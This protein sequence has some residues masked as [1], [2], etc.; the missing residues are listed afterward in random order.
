MIPTYLLCRSTEVGEEEM[1]AAAAPIP[2]LTVITFLF[3]FLLPTIT[4][5]H[6]PTISVKDF[7]AIGDGKHYDTSAIQS[8]IDSCACHT[9]PCYVTFPTGTYLTATFYLKSNVILD[10][11]K[12][13]TILGGTK[14]EDY[15]K[16]SHKWYVILA[17]NASNVGITGG[18]V[19]D[20]QGSEFVVKLDQRKNVMVSWNQT[21]ACSGDEC[22]PRLV[23]FLDSTNVSVSNVTFTQPAYWCLH[24]VRCQNTSIH[25]VSIYG[26]F[27]TPNND[28]IDIEDSNNTVITRCHIDTGDDAICPKT[29]TGPLYN[30]TATNS[31]IRT[32]SSAIKLGSASWFEFKNLVFDNITIVDSH[33]GL[34]FQIRDGGDVNDVTFSN[35]NIS[36]RYYHPSWWGRAEPI[37]VT[38]CPRNS[39]SKEGSEG[40]LLRNL[41]F[42]NINLTYRRW[43]NYKGGLVDYRPGC[44]GLVNHSIAGIIMEHIDGLEVENVNMKWMDGRTV[45]WNNPLDFRPSTVNNISLLNFRSGFDRSGFDTQ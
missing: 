4:R 25:D 30:L 21:G 17:E 8:A 43:T 24:I 34:G 27:N 29:Y 7:G 15:P 9:K 16:E 42:I 20:G 32:K 11:P 18:G 45:Q 38:T 35:I 1:G 10:I 37:Y 39:N 22:R 26:D 12:D 41:R 44:Q 33:R 6:T 14:L 3:L 2:H 28:G 31:W 5:S 23:G 19:V 36:T 40:G 13:T